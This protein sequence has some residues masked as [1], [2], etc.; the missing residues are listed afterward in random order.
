[1][2]NKSVFKYID[3][4][5]LS[6]KESRGVIRSSMILREK[7][8]A[9]GKFIKMKARLVAGG[10]N[11]DKTIYKTL[12]SPTVSGESIM[13]ILAIAASEKRKF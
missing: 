8:D 3:R 6:L 4:S 2:I 9:E 12:S 11:Q 5:K 13:M 7:F 1:M 10:N